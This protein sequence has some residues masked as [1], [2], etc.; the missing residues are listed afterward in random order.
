M[1]TTPTKH[2]RGHISEPE[3]KIVAA[4]QQWKCNACAVILP[5]TYQIDHITALVDGGADSIANAQALC[6]NCHASKTQ[7]EHIKRVRL[8]CSEDKR[9]AYAR[10][11]D[12]YLSKTR[13]MCT[14]CKRERPAHADHEVCQA[15]EDPNYLLRSLQARLSMFSYV[16]RPQALSSD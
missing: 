15:I 7:L 16:A 3:K 1:T 5:P 12:V 9:G 8:S 14:L 4:R 13:V 6:P 2:K 11:E 10:R